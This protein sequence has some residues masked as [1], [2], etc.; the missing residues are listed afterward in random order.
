MQTMN[1]LRIKNEMLRNKLNKMF[2]TRSHD[3]P[4]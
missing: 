2:R 4:R 3:S 1:P